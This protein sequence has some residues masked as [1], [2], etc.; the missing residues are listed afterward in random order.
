MLI[1]RLLQLDDVNLNIF[2]DVQIVP[3][4]SWLVRRVSFDGLYL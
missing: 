3:L 2:R 1:Q 4:R